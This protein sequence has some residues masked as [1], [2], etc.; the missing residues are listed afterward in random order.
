MYSFSCC[1]SKLDKAVAFT[2]PKPAKKQVEFYPFLEY[3]LVMTF[4]VFRIF[5]PSILFT[6]LLT[7]CGSKV[8]QDNFDKIK[9]GMTHQEV[10]AILGK[11]TET[12]QGDFAGLSTGTS[13]W[14]D[15]T[16]VIQIQMLNGKVVLKNF[17]QEAK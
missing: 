14:K 13:T 5:L 10:L 3:I 17:S 1:N 8:T 15:K 16:G 4:K 7:G 11:P 6:I 9:N 12:S 2:M